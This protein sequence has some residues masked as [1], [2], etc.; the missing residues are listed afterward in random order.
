MHM[1]IY[2][3]TC[4]DICMRLEDELGIFGGCRFATL[5]KGSWHA[6]SLFGVRIG[7]NQL[8]KIPR[9]CQSEIEAS[10]C[11]GVCHFEMRVKPITS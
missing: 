11:V 5:A 10:F 9:S 8:F 1:Y 7:Q 3:Y 4:I 6:G 2:I